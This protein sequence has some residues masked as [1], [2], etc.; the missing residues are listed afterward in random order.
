MADR[1]DFPVG[2]SSPAKRASRRTS[3]SRPLTGEVL[4][5]PTIAAGG[6]YWKLTL[7]SAPLLGF[8]LFGRWQEKTRFFRWK[9]LAKIHARRHELVAGGDTLTQ[10]EIE[11]YC[12][13][14]NVVP[15]HS[16]GDGGP[17]GRGRHGPD[18]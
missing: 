4:R 1:L 10:T 18:A 3:A 9:W 11:P 16:D 14:S 7:R 5:R 2:A 17:A 6:R 12:P 8:V 13:G 15:L